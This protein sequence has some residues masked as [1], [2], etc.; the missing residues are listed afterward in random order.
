MKTINW[1]CDKSEMKQIS[2]IVKRANALGLCGFDNYS[3]QTANM[4]IAACH[5]NGN[6]LN[7]D[8]LLNAPDFDFT[9]D[10]CGICRHIDRETGELKN[11][12]S[13][14]CSAPNNT[15][16]SLM[17]RRKGGISHLKMTSMNS[18]SSPEPATPLTPS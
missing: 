6:P 12:F 1:H 11:C 13:P 7:L 16:V 15:L 10:M 14:R 4:D 3:N 9:H 17:E 2:A 8:K 18:G 5:C